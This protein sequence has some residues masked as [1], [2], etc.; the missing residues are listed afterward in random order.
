MSRPRNKE[1]ALASNFQFTLAG[2]IIFSLALIAAASFI[3]VKLTAANHPKLAEVFAVD[4]DDKTRTVQS[5]PW[6]E[7]IMHDIQLERPAEYVTEEVSNPQPEVWTFN[8]MKPD[9]VKALF[10]KNGLSPRTVG[11]GVC[12]GLLQ[13]N[14]L[15]H[16]TPAAGGVFAVAG[17]RHP[18]ETLHPAGRSWR[19]HCIFE[20]PYIFPGD[21]IESIYRDDLLESG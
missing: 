11:C 4:P 7:L 5:G 1:A 18:A 13:G 16:R 8:G 15:R 14:R 9:A 19:Q 17:R 3:T 21:T 10:A 20:F 2:L 12:S 6:G